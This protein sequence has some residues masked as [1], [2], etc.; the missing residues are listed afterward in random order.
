VGQI[1]CGTLLPDS[2][3]KLFFA[4]AQHRK[5]D[6][7]LIGWTTITY[8]SVLA[9]I[10]GV[11]L[12]VLV[13]LYVLFPG[14][15]KSA[16]E[17]M[18]DAIASRFGGGNG[19]GANAIHTG[20]Q[21]ANFTI[22]EG[23]VK[24]KKHTSNAWV[25]ADLKLP[26]EQ[27]DVVQTG[28]EGMARIVFADGSNYVVKQDSLIVIE[29]NT[30]NQQ[31]QT[32]VSVQ[33]TTGTVDLSTAT[34]TQG[35]RSEV[36]VAGATA[37]FSA[38]T[39][40]QVRNDPRDDKHEIMVKKGAGDVTRNG[41]TLK[42]TDFERV[43]FKADS[44][45]MEKM[46]EI[47]PPVLVAP[48]NMMPIFTG[49]V[50]KPVEFSWSPVATAKLYRVKVS[51]NPY[52]S[53]SVLD[54]K[55]PTTSVSLPGLTDGAYYWMVQSVDGE[56]RESI[57]SEKNRFTIIARAEKTTIAL[58]LQPFVQ[59]GR[60]IEIRGKTE[61]GARVMVNG[62]EVPLV[63]QKDGTFQFFSNPLPR[64]ENLITITAQNPQGAA[65]TLQKK[66]VIE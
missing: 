49:G 17:R 33:V 7:S 54:K 11:L 9:A 64:G 4:V 2:T 20:P 13:V 31:Q 36:I 62:R 46:K 8:R 34:Y 21:Q 48:A 24:V 12:L 56:G 35:S 66:V 27:G 60:M 25:D 44:A 57:E 41:E 3:K 18:G 37:N 26:L 51:K 50:P 63:D 43:S 61:P 53:S 6:G 1:S 10:A 52:F 29:Q 47:A 65:N 5:S 32:Q 40:A 14:P 22:I 59:H 28:S 38:D 30:L 23:T 15:F 39:A 42:I 19:A 16:F 55:T 45:H 58:E